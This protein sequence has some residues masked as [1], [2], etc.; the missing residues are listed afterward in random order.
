MKLSSR[1]IVSVVCLVLIVSAV[2]VASGSFILK[3]IE[4]E[5][6]SLSGNGSRATANAL[7]ARSE[8]LLAGHSR[9]ITRERAAMAAL[10]AGDYAE[11]SEILVGT[12]NRIEATGEMT[13][14]T[15]F[16]EKGEIAAT[17]P[18]NKKAAVPPQVAMVLEDGKRQFALSHIADGRF[19][20]AYFVPLLKGRNRI[21]V[22]R[23]VLD[24]NA[25]LEQ[26]A[27][28]IDGQVMLTSGSLSQDA[29]KNG[30]AHSQPT[31]N[32][33]NGE[34][35]PLIELS[36]GA[37]IDQLG[38]E[39]SAVGLV[40]E[41]AK[42]YIVSRE[43]LGPSESGVYSDIYLISD[44]TKQHAAKTTLI[45]TALISVLLVAM[46]IL[47]VMLVWLRRQLTPL[48]VMTES[49]TAL[50]KG[51]VVEHEDF[52]NAAPEISGLQTAMDS[53]V[54]QAKELEEHAA[55]AKLQSED[56]AKQATAL[57]EA[58]KA[59]VA[60]ET[61]RIAQ[62]EAENEVIRIRD[63]K[64]VA[65]ISTVVIACAEG[66]FSRR[67]ETEGKEGV[68]AEICEGINRIGEVTNRGLGEIEVAL[69]ALSEGNLVHRMKGDSSGAFA[70]I[71]LV[72]NDTADSLTSSIRQIEESSMTIGS[73]TQEVSEAAKDLANRTEGSAAT[74]EQTST[75]LQQLSVQISGT[76]EQANNAD[77]EAKEI[78]QLAEAGTSTVENAV[79]AMQE[80]QKSTSLMSK[81][82]TLI[83]DITFQTNL[84]ALNAGVE[85]A[86]AGEAG[87]G[88]AV[89]ASEVRDLAARSS[90]AAR[91][92]AALISSS[93]EQVNE[94]VSLVDQTGSALNSI[95]QGVSRI[96]AKIAEIST[97]ATEQ[98]N[99]VAEINLS[100]KQLDQ[101]TQQN[102]AMFEETSASSVALQ[103][104]AEKLAKVVS[105]F[106]LD[107]E[108]SEPFSGLTSQRADAKNR[109]KPIA[110]LRPANS[111]AEEPTPVSSDGWAEF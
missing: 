54:L 98:S 24:V 91:E 55:L 15:I 13:D 84:L 89:V 17:F 36:F 25:S 23:L 7:L 95:A 57:Q 109:A 102:A 92:I 31:E 63:Q 82:I 75:A 16:N 105:M 59:E 96:A 33:E 78:Q 87:R 29:Q 56:L 22:A 14:L 72:M 110:Q 1:I 93:E 70:D 8:K 48:A 21:G 73:S 20:A 2:F 74:L 58:E 51:R 103:Q 49:I 79:S 43:R 12:F 69:K 32:D 68:F 35:I 81:T 9:V 34:E 106:Q 19:G 97:S 60:A 61:A 52:S 38:A 30:Y 6:L 77:L 88:F 3:Q 100:T 62:R 53:F 10:D 11:L 45:R 4:V 37:I 108:K 26:I 83:D 99:N 18:A 94:G 107:G 27:Q 65:E 64:A 111:F 66:D 39:V 104:E 86:R 28:T 44:F 42:S 5:L 101:A 90:E 47:L 50:A 85:A 46:L 40:T 71:S 67:L 76:A 80:I 41:G